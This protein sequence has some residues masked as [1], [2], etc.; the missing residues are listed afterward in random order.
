[1]K[2]GFLT[3]KKQALAEAVVSL[4]RQLDEAR[5][6][7]TLAEQWE[8]ESLNIPLVADRA[9]ATN[10]HVTLFDLVCKAAAALRKFS[11]RDIE[12]RLRE[13]NPGKKFNL[14]SL[15]RPIQ[16]MVETGRIKLSEQGG[17]SRKQNIYECTNQNSG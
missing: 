10:G 3:K 9:R 5:R 1:M 8:A 4:E 13:D 17:G 15:D 6:Q 12:S 2:D 14:K 16:A 11:K 7:L